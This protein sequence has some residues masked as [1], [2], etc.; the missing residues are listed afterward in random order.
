[1]S[2]PT[3]TSSRSALTPLKE[4]TSYPLSLIDH[5]DRIHRFVKLDSLS[6]IVSDQQDLLQ[7]LFDTITTFVAGSVETIDDDELVASHFSQSLEEVE[8]V[9]Q[10]HGTTR[11]LE[12]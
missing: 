1:M 8:F 6:V 10:D 12:G 11:E 5:L 2:L 3:H 4:K 7:L 9:V